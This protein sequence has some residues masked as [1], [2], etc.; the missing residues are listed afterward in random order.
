MQ[1]CVQIFKRLNS[2]IFKME[3]VNLDELLDIY[4]LAIMMQ[5]Y[6]QLEQHT[7]YRYELMDAACELSVELSPQQ[8][9]YIG[10]SLCDRF[11]MGT[12]MK[13]LEK[14]FNLHKGIVILIKNGEVNCKIAMATLLAILSKISGLN[15]PD[16]ET[17][18]VSR[19]KS[20]FR[21]NHLMLIHLQITKAFEMVKLV[22]WMQLVVSD[23]LT[24]MFVLIRSFSLI[25]NT[26]E[27]RSAHDY[28]H[29]KL[30]REIHLYFMAV[31]RTV[32]SS[33]HYNFFEMMVS[34]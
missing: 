4:H 10:N 3:S 1:F 32:R 11:V 28:W 29:Q 18:I 9:E 2:A 16:Q 20:V 8:L 34:N 30:G 15:V 31:L 21:S 7:S 24:D 12:G 14:V 19:I 5:T 33:R 13:R 25:I 22:N 23:R 6:Q 17:D 26:K 27:N